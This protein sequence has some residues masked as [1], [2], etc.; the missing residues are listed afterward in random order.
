MIHIKKKVLAIGLMLVLHAGL[1]SA[2][3]ASFISKSL[4]KE[5]I[6]GPNGAVTVAD[7][8]VVSQLMGAEEKVVHEITEGVYHIRGWGIAHTIAIDAP[9]GWIIVDTGD[10]TKTA[11]VCDIA[12]YETFREINWV[13]HFLP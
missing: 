3:E 9:K 4:S 8:V 7:A 1:A 5:T 11:S 6:I 2:Q 10:S 12:N 13:T